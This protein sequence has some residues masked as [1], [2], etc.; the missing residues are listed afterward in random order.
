MKKFTI[1]HL[2]PKELNLYGDSGNVMCLYKRMM[3]RNIPCKVVEKGVGDKLNNV[4]FDMIFLGG[5]QDREMKLLQKDLL[6]KA[7]T[8]KYA[9]EDNKTVLAICG[10]YQMLGSYYETKNGE[11]IELLNAIDFY[12]VGTKKRMIGNF[13]YSTPFGNI[14]GFENHSGKTHLGENVEPL[15]TIM[16]GYGNNGVDKTEGLHYKNVY[17]TYSH[18]PVLVKNPNFADEIIKNITHLHELT[19]LDDSIELCCQKY[20]IKRFCEKQ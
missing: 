12:T 18:G 4:D 10:G 5:G 8:I 20:L 6:K 13:V 7:D 3:W 14:V 9:I 15:G 1:L 17:A 19:P 11:H 2:Y 16:R